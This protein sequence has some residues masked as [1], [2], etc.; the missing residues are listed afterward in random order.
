MKALM[1]APEDARC[2]RIMALAYFYLRDHAA[3]ESYLNRALDLNPYDADILAQLG[4][5]LAMRGRAAAGVPLI[6]RSIALN[7]LRPPWY[8]ADLALALYC[9]GQYAEAIG[10]LS[11]VPDTSIFH[12]ASLS[13]FHAMAGNMAKAA[14]HVARA[15]EAAG[16]ADLFEYVRLATE[17]EHEQD[18]QH[19]LDGVRLAVAA[20][21]SQP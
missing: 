2:H 19:F 5:I 14:F 10:A 21:R 18:L 4:F 11:A 13:A 15:L 1:L 6:E 17:F 3:A 12:E 9:L 7:P 20:L 16:D 8:D